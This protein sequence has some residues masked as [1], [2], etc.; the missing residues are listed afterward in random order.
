MRFALP[1]AYRRPDGLFLR[2]WTWLKA[3]SAHSIDRR[4][5][6]HGDGLTNEWIYDATRSVDPR[7]EHDSPSDPVRTCDRWIDRPVIGQSP[8]CRAGAERNVASGAERKGDGFSPWSVGGG[9]GGDGG[10]SSTTELGGSGTGG[11][12]PVVRDGY[13]QAVIASAPDP[14][15][16]ATNRRQRFIASSR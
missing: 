8:R 12:G 4:L 2:L 11:N 6:E 7:I 15:E 16:I 10:T 3:P 5:V 9:P 13:H 14:T 1:I